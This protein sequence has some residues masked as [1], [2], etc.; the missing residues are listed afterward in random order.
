MR[1]CLL[2]AGKMGSWLAR[3]LSPEHQISVFDPRPDALAALSS[4][5]RL[6]TVEQIASVRPELLLNA[7]D[8]RST[9]SAFELALPHV[10]ASCILSDVASVKG[11]L[12]TF[13]SRQAR[14][15]ASIHPMFGPTFAQ[16]DD[17]RGENAVIVRESEGTVK[18]M[19]TDFFAK[20]GVRVFEYS[21]EEHDEMM[22]Y[23]LT[24]PFVSSLVFSSC[25]TMAAVPGT[26]FRKHLEA[27]RGLLGEDDFLL[28]E[29][30]FNP[31][32]LAQLERISSRLNFLW[33]IVKQRDEEE[34]RRYFGGLRSN[35]EIK[36]D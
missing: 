25:V 1:I 6:E 35:I 34:A 26:T 20:R 23:S 3:E 22:A 29:I 36:K 4:V 14:P 15:F 21:L 24:L 9:V 19:W 30:L 31:N 12:G 28:S 5:E 17:L 11:P 13:Y 7:A 16:L 8:L 27:A 2:G 33:H 32:S 10:P 18:Q